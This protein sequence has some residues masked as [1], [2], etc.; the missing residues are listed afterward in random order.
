MNTQQMRFSLYISLIQGIFRRE[1]LAKDWLHRQPVWTREKHS[2]FL[3]DCRDV[4]P[5]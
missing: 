5:G 4:P 1:G 2:P 3:E